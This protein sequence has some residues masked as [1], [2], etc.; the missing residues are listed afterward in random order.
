MPTVKELCIKEKEEARGGSGVGEGK[1]RRVMIFVCM[2]VRGGGMEGGRRGRKKW[3]VVVC[4]GRG[5]G[6][7]VEK[8]MSN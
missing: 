2:C 8:R 3:V 1:G 7:V 5:E 6:G 4:R